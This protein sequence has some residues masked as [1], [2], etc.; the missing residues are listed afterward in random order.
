MTRNQFPPHRQIHFNK[1]NTV[2]PHDFRLITLGRLSLDNGPVTAAADALRK[3]RRKLAVLAHL[4]MERSPV[5]RDTLTDMF[6]GEQEETRARHSLSEALSHLRRVLGP[7]AITARGT[8]VQLSPSAPLTVDALELRAAAA[9]EQW[10]QAIRLHTGAFLDGV[11]P[12]GGARLES[13]IERERQALEQSFLHACERAYA[14]HRS[15]GRWDYALAVARRW[16]EADPLSEAA[17][18][19][20]LAALEAPDTDEAGARALQAYEALRQRLAKEFGTSPGARGQARAAVL[21][22]RLSA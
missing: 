14:A 10:D 12:G 1:V 11:H 22:E 5:P 6:W 16:L 9:A 3:Q 19:A 21:A 2:P 17:A 4:A 18:L 7:N 8:D 13:W 20:V 15:A